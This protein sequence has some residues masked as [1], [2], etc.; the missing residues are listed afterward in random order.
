MYSA[1]FLDLGGTLV[2]IENDEIY[3]SNEGKVD[4]LP[5]V[6]AVLDEAVWQKIFIVTNQSGIS[7][8]L[9]TY[10]MIERAIE[11]VFALS[12]REIDDFWAC[13]WGQS[14]YRK[15]SPLMVTALADKH[16]IDLSQSCFVGDSQNDLLCA[17]AAEIGQF[18][19]ADEFF[20]RT[21]EV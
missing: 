8:Q 16:F 15:P 14:R 6:V 10:E 3:L 13:P 5:N 4:I 19:W 7:S 11:Q 21:G 12:H 9:M 20:R 18:C 17:E 2:R 1:L